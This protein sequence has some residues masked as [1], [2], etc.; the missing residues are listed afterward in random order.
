MIFWVPKSSIL[1]C[2]FGHSRFSSIMVW[3]IRSHVKYFNMFIINHPFWGTLI[4]RNPL[5]LHRW[6][7]PP[8]RVS[9]WHGGSQPHSRP[10]NDKAS[11]I[12][13]G[14]W[15][16]IDH[17]LII[18]VYRLIIYWSSTDIHCEIAPP[19]S[20]LQSWHYKHLGLPLKC[21]KCDEHLPLKICP[22]TVPPPA[23]LGVPP[24]SRLQKSYRHRVHDHAWPHQIWQFQ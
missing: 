1:I 8:L 2:F 6:C 15:L 16:L 19:S 24:P 14:G 17:L 5:K 11:L 18:M 12:H 21:K 3:G 9:W 10:P 22:R 20:N 7:C 13:F 4:L 23:F